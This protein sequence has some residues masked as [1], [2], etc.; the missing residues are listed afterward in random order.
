MGIKDILLIAFII[1]GAIVLLHRSLLKK[2]GYCHGCD[3]GKCETK[4]SGGS[5]DGSKKRCDRQE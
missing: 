2:R 4:V 5:E 3:S 1:A